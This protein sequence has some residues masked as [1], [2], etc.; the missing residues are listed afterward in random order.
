[1]SYCTHVWCSALY[2][3]HSN[4]VVLQ[5][6]PSYLHRCS[7]PPVLQVN[8]CKNR[9]SELKA[10]I[11]QRRVQHSMASLNDN[12]ADQAPDPEEDRAKAQIEQASR[13]LPACAK[14]AL[15]TAP[16]V[17]KRVVHHQTAVVIWSGRWLQLSTQSFLTGGMPCPLAATKLLSRPGPSSEISARS[18]PCP[19]EKGCYKEAFEGL[20]ELK[21]E[22]EHLQMLLEQSR[23]RLQRDFEQ[24]L[25]LMLRQQQSAPAQAAQGLLDSSRYAARQ[26]TTCHHQSWLPLECCRLQDLTG[27]S[28]GTC[29]CQQH[30][31]QTC[32]SAVQHKHLP[33]PPFIPQALV[34]PLQ[35]DS[36]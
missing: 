33:A 31:Q 10:L 5:C 26:A 13:D 23:T 15:S 11:Q 18:S 3:L 1:M 32:K 6:L 12:A 20:R 21:H 16:P 34:Q 7:F 27:L 17:L 9:I 4:T 2:H 36:Q 25:Q 35:I 22:I 29:R 14:S 30:N 19:Q 24:W 28:A 8:D